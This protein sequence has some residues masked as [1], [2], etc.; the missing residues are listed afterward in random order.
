M[1]RGF[2][3]CSGTMWRTP[4]IAVLCALALGAR[5]SEDSEDEECE[6]F[7]VFRVAFGSSM[8]VFAASLSKKGLPPFSRA[9]RVA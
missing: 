5:A 7:P 1:S 2:A 3:C 8:R 4:W 6:S 9:R